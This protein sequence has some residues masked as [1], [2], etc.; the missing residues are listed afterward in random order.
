M[1]KGR[2]LCGRGFYTGRGS[3][4]RSELLAAIHGLKAVLRFWRKSE[5]VLLVSDSTYLLQ[6]LPKC[7]ISA[8]RGVP[9]SNEWKRLHNIMQTYASHG[10]RCLVY[11]VR[12][13]NG[14]HGNMLCDNLARKAAICGKDFVPVQKTEVK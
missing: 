2:L 14:T 7:A 8:P 12:G 5:D 10:S 11:W 4:N 13:H 3:N 9:N 6:G 1:R